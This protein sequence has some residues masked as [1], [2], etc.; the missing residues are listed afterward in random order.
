MALNFNSD[1]GGH[2]VTTL[3]G[4]AR[5]EDVA[6]TQAELAAY[7]AKYRDAIEA[8]GYTADQFSQAYSVPF[9]VT[10]EKLATAAR[11][12]LGELDAEEPAVS[13]PTTPSAVRS[14]C[15]WWS[16]TPSLVSVP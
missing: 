14:F 6:P 12:Q 8:L 1:H 16:T 9:R 5:L 3:N 13:G 11:S 10:L 7:T 4:T 15:R 2:R